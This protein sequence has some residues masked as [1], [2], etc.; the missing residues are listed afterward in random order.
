VKEMDPSE[1]DEV[2]RLVKSLDWYHTIDLG[3]GII[4]PGSYDH[5]SYLQFYGLP[6]DLAGKTALDIG[7]GSGFFAFEMERR[8][9]KV[10]ATD[11][12][13]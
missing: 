9:A 12:P 3:Q 7:A 11:L 2:K 6:E 13:Q 10:T 5:R 8:G 4:T 1:V